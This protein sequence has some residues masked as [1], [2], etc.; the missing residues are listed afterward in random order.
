[1][2]VQGWGNWERDKGGMFIR[3]GPRGMEAVADNEHGTDDWTVTLN[4]RVRW[5]AEVKHRSRECAFR[6][7][8]AAAESLRP[9][10]KEGDR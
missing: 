10:R 7:C 2:T 3:S 6:A 5:I 9:W 1:M 4:G 8:L